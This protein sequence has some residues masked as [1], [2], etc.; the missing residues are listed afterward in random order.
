MK[1]KILIINI[2]LVTALF[3]NSFQQGNIEFSKGNLLE[4]EKHYLNDITKR[5]ETFNTLYNLGAL[6]ISLEK[7]GY[8]KYY[9]KKAQLLNPR[10]KE[11]NKLLNNREIQRTFFRKNEIIL[12]N[13]VLLF[14]FSIFITLYIV[15]IYFRGNKIKSLKNMSVLFLILTI[16]SF[17]FNIF[18]KL[19]GNQGITLKE[20]MVY[21]SP[22]LES[23]ES[24]NINQAEKVL[25]KDEYENYYY[26]EDKIGRYGWILKD[27]IGELWIQ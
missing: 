7:E 22:Y 2:F 20:S 14:L 25:I 4:A 5:G 1:I 18:S 3:S 8:S 6:S 13:A 9:L 10:D 12:L 15:F 19:K 21:L 23:E 24:F 26:L 11:L 16:G 27:D 17:G